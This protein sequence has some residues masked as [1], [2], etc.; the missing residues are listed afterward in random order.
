[1]RE[2][3]HFEIMTLLK[4]T[5]IELSQALHDK[6]IDLNYVF[7]RIDEINEYTIMLKIILDRKSD[8]AR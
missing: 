6:P 7:A 5:T 1:M 2:L 4:A 8:N 3:A